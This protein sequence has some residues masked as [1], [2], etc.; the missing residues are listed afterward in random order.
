MTSFVL[1]LL[2]SSTVLAVLYLLYLL[3]MRKET[4]FNLNRFFLL[5]I[6]VFSL[7]FPFLS[8]DIAPIRIEAMEVPVQEISTIRKDFYTSL[9]EWAFEVYSNGSASNET[10]EIPWNVWVFRA[11]FWVYLGGLVLIL[12]RTIGS[13]DWIVLTIRRNQTIE[14]NGYKIVV[15]TKKIAPFSFLNYVFVHE[16]LIDTEEY[17]QIVAH[18]RAHAREYH[19]V[20]LIIVQLLAAVFWFNPVIWQ[21]SKSLKTIHEYIADQKMINS[22]YSLV[23]YQTLLLKQLVSNNSYGLVHNFNLTFI[24]KRITMMTNNKSGKTGKLKVALALF[25]TVLF[26]ILIVQC[27]SKLDDPETLEG[28]ETP[29]GVNSIELDLPYLPGM[30]TRFDGN[31]DNSVEVTISKNR[32]WLDG[33]EYEVGQIVQAVSKKNL[34]EHSIIVMTVDKNQS[35]SIVFDVQDQ[36]RTVQRKVLYRGINDSGERADMA[37]LLPPLPGKAMPDG[38]YLPKI[39]DKYIAAKGIEVLKIHLGKNEGVLNEQRVEQMVRKHM[40]NGSSEYVVSAKADEDDTFGEYLTNLAYINTGFNNIYQ[41]RS[42]QMFGKNYL[43]LDKSIPEEKE[44]YNAVRKGIPR[45]ISIA[46]RD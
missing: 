31:L 35:M 9:D 21:L 19:S 46:E 38:S 27:N 42:Q 34:S 3:A 23:E 43:E 37:M 13:L 28:L 45:A 16:D 1:Y 22:G 44:Q 17:E 40:A 33:D 14:K 5:G 32:V 30:Y 4:F 39:D 29:L 18:E 26:S 15:L 8:F 2:E 24:K 11:V 25:S 12:G 7:L 36:L 6:L 20:D 41:E 10:T